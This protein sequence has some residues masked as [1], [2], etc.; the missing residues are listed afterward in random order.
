[1]WGTYMEISEEEYK[2]IIAKRDELTNQ[3]THLQESL[4]AVSKENTLL[5]VDISVLKDQLDAQMRKAAVQDKIGSDIIQQ[6]LDFKIKEN[7]ELNKK[8]DELNLIINELRE[9]SKKYN[10]LLKI[11]KQMEQEILFLKTSAESLQK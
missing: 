8:I 11:N 9:Y 4:R 2:K 6:R 7:V 5:K 1:M 3:V 10:E